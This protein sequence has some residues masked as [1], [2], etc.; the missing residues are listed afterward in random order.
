MLHSA[1][2]QEFKISSTFSQVLFEAVNK[3]IPDRHTEMPFVGVNCAAA[4]YPRSRSVRL[5]KFKLAP[6]SQMR[7]SERLDKSAA[8]HATGRPFCCIGALDT[9]RDHDDHRRAQMAEE[10]F[11]TNLMR[12]IAGQLHC[13][14]GMTAAREMFGKSYFSLGIAEKIAVDNAL[15]G[16]VAANFQAITPAFLAAQQAQQPV[17]FGIP[18]AAPTKEKS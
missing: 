1:R 18:A 14:A 15:N 8:R 6:D 2:F 10:N 5:Q 9:V 13:L 17:G 11:N 7:E 4:D 3:V 16:I 12:M